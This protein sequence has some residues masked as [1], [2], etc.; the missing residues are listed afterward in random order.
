MMAQRLDIVGEKYARLL[1]IE[2][3][4][5]DKH[6][7]SQ[8]KCLCDCGNEVTTSGAA[9][10]KGNTTSCGCYNLERVG[11]MNYKHGGCGSGV[12]FYHPNYQSWMA[13]RQRC[14][15]E[16]VEHYCEYGGRG[17]IVQES[18]LDE[19]EGLKN[20]TEDMGLR[21]DG[22]SLDRID[23]NGN[24]TKENCRWATDSLQAYN[25]RQ[26]KNNSSGRTGV[27][28]CKKT[29]TWWAG[30]CKDGKFQRL[31]GGMNYEDACAV[32][33][34]AELEVYGFNKE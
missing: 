14:Y 30:I 19:F 15:L 9:M 3:S 2:Y 26:S 28:L 32:R 27:Y 25:T 5:Q 22:L 33:A 23:P 16:T 29:D 12:E 10:R 17:I 7:K 34:A 4:H 18:W 24:Y 11:Q 21:P 8:W 6:G 20:F 1:V 13:M 31:K